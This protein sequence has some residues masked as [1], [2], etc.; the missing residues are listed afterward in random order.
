MSDDL[1][2]ELSNPIRIKILFL[3][4]KEAL[5][6]T[7][8]AEEV[9]KISKSEISRHLSRLIERGFIQKEV[10]SGRRYQLTS[11]GSVIIRLYKPINFLFHHSEFFKS[12]TINSLPSFLIKDIDNLKKGEFLDDAGKVMFKIKELFSVSFDEAWVMGGTAFPFDDWS[13]K[14]VN[15]I[16]TP[17][18]AKLRDEVSKTHPETQMRAS[19]IDEINIAIALTSIGFGIINF[20][21]NMESKPDYNEAIFISDT[22][23]FNYLK[24]IWNYFWNKG[25]LIL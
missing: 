4:K 21:K 9:G 18:L 23:G 22:K 3:L 24:T 8:I 17:N 13:A 19:V 11:F 25:E 7:T 12:H 16:I 1:I 20:P 5:T 6:L 14:K 15:Y 10:P 2:S